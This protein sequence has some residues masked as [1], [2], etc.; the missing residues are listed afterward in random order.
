VTLKFIRW[1]MLV[2]GAVLHPVLMTHNDRAPVARRNL[3]ES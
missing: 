1:N 3:P 2:N